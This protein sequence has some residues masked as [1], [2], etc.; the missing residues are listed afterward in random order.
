MPEQLRLDHVVIH[1]SEWARSLQF[2]RAVLGAEVVVNEE[3]PRTP[4]G[5]GRCG[6]CAAHDG[7]NRAYVAVSGGRPG[8]EEALGGMP[9]VSSFLTRATRTSGR[10]AGGRGGLGLLVHENA[11]ASAGAFALGRRPLGSG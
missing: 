10:G 1:V 5:R 7:L 3:A 8:D 9:G 11:P 2:Y 6:R 4:R